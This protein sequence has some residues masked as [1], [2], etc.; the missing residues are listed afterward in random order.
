M[1]LEYQRY[2]VIK[3]AVRSLVL[4]ACLMWLLGAPIIA[5][6]IT[7][8]EIQA[9]CW[10]EQQCNDY[11]G[12]WGKGDAFKDNTVYSK[13]KKDDSWSV[14]NCK[15]I[16]G[17][18]DAK[19][20][21][22][23]FAGNPSIPLQIGI[24]GVTERY[25]SVYELGKDPIPCD[26]D[27]NICAS[28]GKGTCQPGIKGGFPGYLA[29]F[30]KF[31]VAAL[32]VI[33]VVM[34]MWGGFKRIMAA[35]SPERVKSANETIIGAITGVVIALISY[36]LLNLINPQLVANTLPLIE[37]VK[38]DF[39]GFCPT[40]QSD[41]GL[42]EG[43]WINRSGICASGTRELRTCNSDLDCPGSTE[44]KGC[45]T[46]E[47]RETQFGDPGDTCG[48]KLNVS[49]RD[50]IGLECRQSLDRGCFSVPN[51]DPVRRDCVPYMLKG[52]LAGIEVNSLD[53]LFI[54]QD[55]T[56]TIRNGGS[57]CGV[58]TPNG[59]GQTWLNV[60]GNSTYAI[61][62]CWG[63]DGGT[64][65]PSPLT[66]TWC[67]NAGGFKGIALVVEVESTDNLVVDDYYAIDAAF[68]SGQNS[69]R[70]ISS[71]G[72]DNPWGDI[73]WA[74]VSDT[75]LFDTYDDNGRLI[76]IKCD[77]SITRAEFPDR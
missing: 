44:L 20:T 74:E 34:V 9:R 47:G 58:S 52:K 17:D 73:N 10:T 14:E 5:L 48:V 33:A 28:S 57:D 66:P 59:S 22:R 75:K 60:E 15:D 18:S 31:F 56:T 51:T 54:C 6:A 67:R 71:S 26:A 70:I 12:I 41:K 63:T 21:A 76:P 61:G 35:G 38:P 32:A 11:N 50:C 37:K 13:D 46:K 42:Y 65:N 19:H 39:F 24:P 45:I 27:P 30:Y 40:Y 2:S 23:C 4:G 8:E 49:G 69:K 16:G 53:M 62:N 43:G 77:L 68:C 7:D 55:S 64:G 1:L 36:T 25:C 29:A 72:K 3:T